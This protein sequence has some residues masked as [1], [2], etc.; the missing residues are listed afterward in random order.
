[1][2]TPFI[3][4]RIPKVIITKYVD[5]N[6]LLLKIINYKEN[7]FCQMRIPFTS[8]FSSLSV[9][10]EPSETKKIFTALTVTVPHFYC[11]F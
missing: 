8:E 11:F 4:I 7:N 6:I 5:T 10:L 9:D 3:L 1:M 2:V